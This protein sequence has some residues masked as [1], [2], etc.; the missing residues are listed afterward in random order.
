MINLLWCLDFVQFNLVV[1][2][3]PTNEYICCDQ[4]TCYSCSLLW[5]CVSL[6]VLMFGKNNSKCHKK[7]NHA[8]KKNLLPVTSVVSIHE[9]NLRFVSLPVIFCFSFIHSCLH[10]LFLLFKYF[11]SSVLKLYNLRKIKLYNRSIRSPEI[12]PEVSNDLIEEQLIPQNKMRSNFTH[13]PSNNANELLMKQKEH[14]RKAFDYITKALKIDEE[15][16]G[17]YQYIVCSPT[18]MLENFFCS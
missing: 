10:F 16:N 14:H 11:W 9:K 3:N 17:K 12:L 18:L 4:D 2:Y 15:N 8:E 6:S 13:S 7:G 5:L 1:D